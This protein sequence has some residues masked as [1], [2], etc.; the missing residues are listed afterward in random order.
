LELIR[1]RELVVANPLR[2]APDKLGLRKAL[3]QR[4]PYKL[5]YLIR[6][7]DLYVAA[8]AHHKRAPG[9]WETRNRD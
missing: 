3:L 6:Q 1:V 2:C 8:A 5:V 4:F 9:Y 7:H